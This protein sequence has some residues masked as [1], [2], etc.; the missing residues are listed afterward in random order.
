MNPE[1]TLEERLRRLPLR[2]PPESLDAWL[3]RRRAFRR[4]RAVWAL[5]AAIVLAIGGAAG[6][7]FLARGG[8]S[9]DRIT[10]AEAAPLRIDQ[11]WSRTIDGGTVLIDNGPHRLLERQTLRH[12]WW[13]DPEQDV[14]Y[15]VTVPQ[16]EIILVAERP[17]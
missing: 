13:R 5:A 15:E 16:T 1:R 10:T 9:D 6:I 7:L 3:R 2:P 11:T 4:R 8:G 17:Y 14:R 12:V